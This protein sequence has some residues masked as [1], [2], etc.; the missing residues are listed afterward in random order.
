MLDKYDSLLR[1]LKRNKDVQRQG[2]ATIKVGYAAEVFTYK[3]SEHIC[4][5]HILSLYVCMCVVCACV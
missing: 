4:N 3:G 1:S 2:L 5:M